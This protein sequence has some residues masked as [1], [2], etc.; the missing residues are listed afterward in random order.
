MDLN[1][2]ESEVRFLRKLLVPY[3]E[4]YGLLARTN[5][6]NESNRKKSEDLRKLNAKLE[7]NSAIKESKKTD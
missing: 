7:E 1:L 2:S 3:L 4:Y 5:Y 6:C